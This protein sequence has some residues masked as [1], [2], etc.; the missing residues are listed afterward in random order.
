M[1]DR[2]N[3]RYMTAGGNNHNRTLYAGHKEIVSL[4]DMLFELVLVGGL[5]QGIVETIHEH[6]VIPKPPRA[7]EPE[8]VDHFFS[9][10]S[11]LQ[12]I[13]LTSPSRKCRTEN[14]TPL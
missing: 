11:V 7:V 4:I 14:S 5:V 6:L 10:S 12:Y 8:Y 9:N 13:L 1:S 2:I 3:F